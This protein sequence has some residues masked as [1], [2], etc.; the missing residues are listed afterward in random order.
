MRRHGDLRNYGDA[1]AA[2]AA[3]KTYAEKHLA[4]AGQFIDG[5]DF[6]WATGWGW[7]CDVGQL[8]GLGG[9]LWI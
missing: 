1:P 3:A 7:R 9:A 5:K 6:L 2:V 8:S 4:V